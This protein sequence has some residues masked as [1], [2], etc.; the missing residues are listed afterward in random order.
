MKPITFFVLL[1]TMILFMTPLKMSAQEDV[2]DAKTCVVLTLKDCSEYCTGAQCYQFTNNCTYK[3]K[4]TW[5]SKQPS[6]KWISGDVY[7]DPG[8]TSTETYWCPYIEVTWSYVK[9]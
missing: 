9:A 5:K 3:V 7:L 6:G 2:S 8:E 1:V 4:V